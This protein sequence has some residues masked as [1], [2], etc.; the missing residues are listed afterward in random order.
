MSIA[1]KSQEASFM[2]QQ[3]VFVFVCVYMCTCVSLCIE[4]DIL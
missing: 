3:S 4:A 1:D 2:Q